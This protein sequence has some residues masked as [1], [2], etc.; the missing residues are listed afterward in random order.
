MME[1]QISLPKIQN[2]FIIDSK[3]PRLVFRGSDIRKKIK[4]TCK[5]NDLHLQNYIIYIL[6][7]LLHTHASQAC[8]RRSC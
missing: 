4:L 3:W 6:S 7:R 1:K 2:A 8:S 5:L